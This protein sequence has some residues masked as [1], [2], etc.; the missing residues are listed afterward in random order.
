MSKY[1]GEEISVI[2]DELLT[3]IKNNEKSLTYLDLCVTKGLSFNELFH[4]LSNYTIN[5]IDFA[6]SIKDSDQYYYIFAYCN[7]DY[8]G[9][10]DNNITDDH[11]MHIIR[12]P[13]IKSLTIRS[14]SVTEVGIRAILQNRNITELELRAMY[15]DNINVN[16]SLYL[17][18]IKELQ[19]ADHLTKLCLMYCDSLL[20]LPYLKEICNM[21][22]LKSIEFIGNIDTDTKNYILSNCKIQKV[23][24]DNK[25][26]TKQYMLQQKKIKNE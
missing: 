1:N 20:E 8:L 14:S 6:E 4:I 17:K 11:L 3:E 23:K 22:Q 18:V 13:C 2:T 19:Q 12:N 21:K 15:E 10:F 25:T 5:A 24:I 9:V 7:A 26:Y 16:P